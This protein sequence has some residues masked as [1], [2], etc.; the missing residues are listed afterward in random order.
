[1]RHNVEPRLLGEICASEGLPCSGLLTGLP[2]GTAAGTA[3]SFG[4][5][6]FG[7]AWGVGEAGRL[8]GDLRVSGLLH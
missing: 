3:G 7:I 8:V 2:C 1:M 5:A 6:A 4:R